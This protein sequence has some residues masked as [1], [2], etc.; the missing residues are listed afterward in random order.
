MNLIAREIFLL[1]RERGAVLQLW[2]QPLLLLFVAGLF[3]PAD[4]MGASANSNHASLLL[5]FVILLVVTP[6]TARLWHDDRHSGA[7]EQ[8]YLLRGSLLPV[9]LARWLAYYLFLLLPIVLLAVAVRWLWLQVP[10]TGSEILALALLAASVLAL[11]QL[12]A[13]LTLNLQQGALL[14][15]LLLVPFL[16]PIFIAYAAVAAVPAAL[17]LLAAAAV[18]AV[19]LGSLATAAILRQQLCV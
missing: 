9:V 13:A 19:P 8:L 10:V 17:Y 4:S 5:L 18:L 11:S 2:L 14:T 15:A 16:L 12:V 3:S 7:L 6:L 1:W